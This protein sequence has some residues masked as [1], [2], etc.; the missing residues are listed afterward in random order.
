MADFQP[1]ENYFSEE[2][3]NEEHKISTTV[4]EGTKDTTANGEPSDISSTRHTKH[5]EADILRRQ[6]VVDFESFGY[7][8]LKEFDPILSS[9]KNGEKLEA[10]G[11][12]DKGLIVSGNESSLRHTAPPGLLSAEESNGRD[13]A[14]SGRFVLV[15][16]KDSAAFGQSFEYSRY[17][18]ELEKAAKKELEQLDKE[19]DN[20]PATVAST[21]YPSLSLNDDFHGVARHR[22]L[23]VSG[24]D[25][26]GRLVIVFSASRIPPIHCIDH[27]MLFLYMKH[28]LDQYVESDY[29][30]VYFHYGLTSKNK[31]NFSW[32]HQIYKELDR[33]YRKNVKALFIV[34]PSNFIKVLWGFFRK[35]ASLKFAKKVTYINYLQELA[36]HV[37][38]NQIDIPEEVLEH[39]ARIAVRYKPKV[40]QSVFHTT[41]PE[42]P[43]T[44]QFGV[45]LSWLRETNN[46]EVIP[47]AIRTSVEFI[48]ENGLDVEGIFRRSANSQMVK[49]VTV[50]FNQ[51]TPV[52]YTELGDVHCAAAIIKKFL[53]E[54]PEP[55]LTYELCDVINEIVALGDRDKKLMETWSALHNRLPAENFALLKFIMEFLQEV[56]QHPANKMTA[57]NLAIVFGPNLIW[58]RTAASSLDAMAQ[59]NTFTC[60]VLENTEYL[61]SEP[62][63]QAGS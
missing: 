16:D 9:A 54:L 32:L 21:F 34:H 63:T 14:M 36:E 24:A 5:E 22:I 56:Q 26:S 53:R 13:F 39:D 35:I 31:P 17:D 43:K 62:E 46:G 55:L 49:Q 48:Q 59:I 61:F 52:D 3:S 6:G 37:Q 28:T 23:S 57:S 40:G 51:G 20:L 60:L 38:L 19:K 42:I 8:D 7:N 10:K 18:A 1:L 30:I 58:G 25:K 33:K 41:I 2:M 44:Q 27:H 47:R 4:T 50:M 12:S 15:T 45:A 11:S 29:T